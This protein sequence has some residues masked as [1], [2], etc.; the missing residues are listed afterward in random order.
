MTGSI[1]VITELCVERRGTEKK[2]RALPPRKSDGDH[3][4]PRAGEAN[5][6]PGKRASRP[7]KEPRVRDRP[8]DKRVLFVRE[9]H[10]RSLNIE[11]RS[12][13]SLRSLEETRGSYR[14][15]SATRRR[16]FNTPPPPSLLRLYFAILRQCG[17]PLS[18][19]RN[20][21]FIYVDAAVVPFHRVYCR[22]DRYASRGT[23][24]LG[25]VIKDTINGPP[26]KYN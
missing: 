23:R 22:L 14:I 4:R 1:V 5:D 11:A 8:R 19:T 10:G 9:N 7:S 13:R 18:C 24:Y 20:T 26:I 16:S 2:K 15:N 3:P 21:F 25:A 6:S 12:R 17:G